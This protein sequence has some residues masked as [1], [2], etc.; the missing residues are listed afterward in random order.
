MTVSVTGVTVTVMNT[1]LFPC[2]DCNGLGEIDQHRGHDGYVCTACRG[3]GARLCQ[4]CGQLPAVDRVDGNYACAEC[5]PLTVSDVCWACLTDTPIMMHN[6]LALCGRC[7]DDAIR[8]TPPAAPKGTHWEC[9]CGATHFAEDWGPGTSVPYVECGCSRRMRKV[10]DTVPCLPLVQCDQA[11]A[12]TLPE[13]AANDHTPLLLA[14]S[15]ELI[16]DA[17]AA[18]VEPREAFAIVRRA[19]AKRAGRMGA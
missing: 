3:T 5:L 16:E 13:T 2:D 1:A 18:G 6:G 10:A 17:R 4:L 11:A 12:E 8:T 7:L 14:E 9:V 15:L 19:R